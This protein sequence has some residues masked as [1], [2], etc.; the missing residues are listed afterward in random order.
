MKFE[1]ITL[2]PEL[3]SQGMNTGVVG[4]AVKKEIISYGLTNPRDFTS[5]VHRTV[6]DRPYGGGDGMLMLAE[7]LSQAIETVL[8]RGPAKVIYTSPQGRQLD[9]KMVRELSREKSLL[10]ICGRYGGIDQRLINEYVDEQISIGDYVVSG[11]ELPALVICDSVARQIP[12]VLG[13]P[14]SPIYDSFSES[15]L[16]APQ[17]TRPREF[18]GQNVP[19][20][21]LSGDHRKIEELRQALSVVT[22]TLHRPDLLRAKDLSES[23]FRRSLKVLEGLSVS[24]LKACGLGEIEELLDKGL[25]KLQGEGKS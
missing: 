24:E 9:Q 10:L 20:F 16:E 4:Q 3:I 5:D 6:D 17:F 11:G 8:R 13:N 14:S 12:G 25:K 2:F 19:G 21:F 1:F 7:P 18:R 23:D 22:T 15:L